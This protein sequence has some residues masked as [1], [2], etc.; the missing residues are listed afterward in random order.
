MM[1]VLLLLLTQTTLADNVLDRYTTLRKSIPALSVSYTVMAGKAPI[2]GSSLIDRDQRLFMT[3]KAAGL[4]YTACIT[5]NKVIELDNLEKVYDEYAG[6]GHAFIP[7]SRLTSAVELFPS[8]IY[9]QDLRKLVP[10]GAAF[11]ISEPETVSG[12]KCD[13]VISKFKG[14]ENASGV[15]DA[16]LDSAGVVRRMRITHSSPMGASD[17]EWRFSTMKPMPPTDAGKFGLGLPLGYVPYGLPDTGMPI[18][19]D[20][21][22][23]MTGWSSPSG[24][25]DLTAKLGAKGGLIA[26]LGGE[27][28][29]SALAKASLARVSGEVPVVTLGDGTAQ[30]PGLDG[31]DATGKLMATV[32][33]PA[34]PFFALVDGKGKVRRLWM[35][36]EPAKASEFEADIRKSFNEKE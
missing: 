1:H 13:R 34:T 25:L 11:V 14:P 24:A 36:F 33:P 15:V 35:G 10:K 28:E 2:S 9:L 31:F 16:S 12:I 5:P 6:N 3:M 26:I 20:A 17:F 22:F 29:P 7:P 32:N 23:P 4:D 30:A 27:S 21:T 19:V 8:W 18:S